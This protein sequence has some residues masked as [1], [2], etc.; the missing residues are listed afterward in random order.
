[1][2]LPIRFITFENLTWMNHPRNQNGFY[3]MSR[4]NSG[5]CVRWVWKYQRGN[6]NPYIEEELTTQ[7]PKEKVQ[8]SKQWSTKHT[9]K[10]KDR[11][12]RTPLKTG[13]KLRCFGR[14]S[15]FC[16]TR[17]YSIL[18][19]NKNKLWYKYWNEYVCMKI[20]SLMIFEVLM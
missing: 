13:G 2:S 15:R 8:K 17:H 1:L 12:T 20:F 11:L 16:S 4:W 14:V 6:Q 18:F 7:W 9:H 19:N 10:T 3:I 5:L